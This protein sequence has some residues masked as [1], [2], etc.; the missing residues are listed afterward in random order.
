MGAREQMEY[1]F[2]QYSEN[3]LIFVSR[4]YAEKFAEKIS[5][6]V[7]YKTLSRMCKSEYLHRVSKGVYCRPEKTR[8][9]MAFP[10][11]R[12]ITET[13]TEKKQGVIVGYSLYNSLGLTTQISKRIE[14]YSSLIEE[15]VK[16]IGNIFIKK[17]S[18]T[19]DDSSLMVIKMLEVLY[20]YREIEDIN[21][22]QFIRFCEAY[23][24]HYNELTTEYIIQQINYPKW[25]IAFLREVLDY[26]HVEN[27]LNKHLSALSEY[28]IPKMEDIYE[29]A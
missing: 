29:T 25:T 28:K 26:Y 15:N 18:L 21:N 7:Y 27:N 10:S 3:E 2:S 16:Q 24:K 1:V 13:F 12:K 5:E 11:E 14:V 19:F 22:K 9:G 8:F 20:H 6:T 4:L 17:V 23:V